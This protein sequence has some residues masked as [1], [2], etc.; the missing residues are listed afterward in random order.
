MNTNRPASEIRIGSIKAT[1]W[2]NDVA[3]EKY[4]KREKRYSV[5]LCRLYK[6]KDSDEWRTTDSLGKED[7]LVAAKVLDQAHTWI[8]ETP[9]GAE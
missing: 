2:A 1:I 4:E 5:K 8:V 3:D 7:L 6:E 9:N